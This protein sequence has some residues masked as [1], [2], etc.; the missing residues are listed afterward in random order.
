MQQINALPR[1]AM[2]ATSP[3]QQPTS[4]QGNTLALNDIHVPEPIS[5]FPIAYGWW[6]LTALLLGAIFYVITKIKRNS[7]QNKVKKQALAQLSSNPSM[8]NSDITALLKWAAMHYF[9]RAEIAKLFG[10]SLQNFLLS[11][12]PTNKQQAFSELCEETFLNQYQADSSAQT[13]EKFKQAAILWLTT[14][15]PPKPLKQRLNNIESNPQTTN[16]GVSA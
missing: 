5:N 16:K 12:L 13:N 3:I 1:P 14:A 8:N 9:S 2:Q 4:M 15:L 10:D 11:K 6:I 7:R